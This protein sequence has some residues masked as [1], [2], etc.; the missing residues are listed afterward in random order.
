MAS[1]DDTNVM[2]SGVPAYLSEVG[3]FYETV[4]IPLADGYTATW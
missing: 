1:T 3:W 2:N 4:Y